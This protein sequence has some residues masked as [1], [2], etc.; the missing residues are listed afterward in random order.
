MNQLQKIISGIILI[1]VCGMVFLPAQWSIQD[2]LVQTEIETTEEA[3][4]LSSRYIVD[5]Y[6]SLE[7]IS[8]HT[9]IWKKIVSKLTIQSLFMNGE[10]NGCIHVPPPE[11]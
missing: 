10:P 5:L 9:S 3:N 8:L 1:L 4:E 11:K 6:L 2:N 7:G